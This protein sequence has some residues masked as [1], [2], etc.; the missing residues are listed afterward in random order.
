MKPRTA[1]P[2]PLDYFWRELAWK[3]ER[4]FRWSLCGLAVLVAVAIAGWWR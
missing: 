3:Y 2:P 1:S 4:R